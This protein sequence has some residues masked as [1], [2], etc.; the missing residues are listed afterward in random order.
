MSSPS[1]RL[2]S[3][4]YMDGEVDCRVGTWCGWQNNV[5]AM[6]VSKIKNCFVSFD[7]RCLRQMHCCVVIKGKTTSPE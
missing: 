3:L 5:G 4:L 6:D 2:F 1:V 7:D